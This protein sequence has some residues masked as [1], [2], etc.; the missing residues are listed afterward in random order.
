MTDIQ[1]NLGNVNRV[2]KYRMKLKTLP[3]NLSF[4]ATAVTQVVFLSKQQGPGKTL[5]TNY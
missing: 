2:S 1:I 5:T 4:N 3:H